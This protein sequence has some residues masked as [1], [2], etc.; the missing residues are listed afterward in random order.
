MLF[1]LER[2][3]G[4][5]VDLSEDPE[6][7]DVL[8]DLEQIVW[9]GITGDPAPDRFTEWATPGGPGAPTAA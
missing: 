9:A 5:T 6:Y 8:A 1:D 4:E 3:P 2:D 7:A